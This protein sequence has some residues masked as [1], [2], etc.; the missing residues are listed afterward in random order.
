MQAGNSQAKLLQKTYKLK[1]K[2]GQMSHK[3]NSWSVETTLR[4]KVDNIFAYYK[5][6][7]G[8]FCVQYRST[9]CCSAA[10]S[11]SWWLCVL[12]PRDSQTLIVMGKNQHV[13]PHNG[14][15][16][17]R[18]EGNSWVTRMYETQRQAQSAAR[19]IA[20]KEKSEVVIHRPNGQIRDKDSYGNDPYPPKG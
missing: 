10:V 3:K 11:I 4:K 20:I 13:V 5:S 1:Y 6:L 17:V 9:G 2:L 12:L 14:K 8:I 19:R 15:W 16:A 18:G 7:S